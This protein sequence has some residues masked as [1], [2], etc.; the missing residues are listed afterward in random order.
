[1]SRVL[2]DAERDEWSVVVTHDDREL[3]CAEFPEGIQLV[4]LHPHKADDGITLT[5]DGKTIGHLPADLAYFYRPVNRIIGAGMTMYAECKVDVINGKSFLVI[6]YI[7]PQDLN[8]WAVNKVSAYRHHLS[9]KRRLG[10]APVHKGTS[11]TMAV[12]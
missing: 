4:Q 6:P 12:A 5:L 3:A 2:L 1:M 10:A 8:R 9:V 7:H 11:R